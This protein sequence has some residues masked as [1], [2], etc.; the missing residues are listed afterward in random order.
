MRSVPQDHF[1]ASRTAHRVRRPAPAGGHP[2]HVR[3]VVGRRGHQH[4]IAVRHDDGTGVPGE[5]G[6]QGALDVIDLADSVELVA[7]EVQQHD[8]GRFHRVGDVRYVHLIDLEGGQC[9]A[10]VGGQCGN[11]AG[12]HVGAFAVGRDRS[13][14]G[15]RRGHH[16]GGGGLAV[17]AGDD[18]TAPPRAELSQN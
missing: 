3:A 13:D 16:S 7:G 17:G 5:P 4:V 11:Q 8:N 1:T 9:G 2:H 10:P 15:Q 18:R 6:P 12:I 14:G